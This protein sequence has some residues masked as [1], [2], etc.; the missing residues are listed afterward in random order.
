MSL[1]HKCIFERVL[2][3]TDADLQRQHMSMIISFV[4]SG[5]CDSLSRSLGHVDSVMCDSLSW[6]LDR[7]SSVMCDSVSRSLGHM[8]SVM[9]D[10]VSR[11]LGRMSSVICDSLSWSLGRMSS[12]MCDKCIN[13]IRYNS[14][15]EILS[16]AMSWSFDGQCCLIIGC[17]AVMQ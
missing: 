15:V 14:I 16:P 5:M 8:D 9:C 11:S 6:S 10:S 12:V 17:H 13:V 3:A 2:I 1:E 7:M 4:H